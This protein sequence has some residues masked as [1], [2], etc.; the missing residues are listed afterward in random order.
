[1]KVA[2]EAERLLRQW[3][4]LVSWSLVLDARKVSN[5]VYDK[6]HICLEVVHEELWKSA[7]CRGQRAFR[8]F[9]IGMN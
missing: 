5:L 3:G 9:V 2:L 4:E 1:M 6:D 7:S 8:L